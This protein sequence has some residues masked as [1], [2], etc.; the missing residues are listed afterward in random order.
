[1]E[2]LTKAFRD[3]RKAGYYAKQNFY[4]CQSCGWNAIPED[5]KDKVVFYHDQDAEILEVYGDC[6]LSWNGDGNEIVRILESNGIKTE[7]DGTEFQRIRIF[8]DI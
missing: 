8:L 7:W 4:C 6:Y 2:K 1:M 3:L 5:M